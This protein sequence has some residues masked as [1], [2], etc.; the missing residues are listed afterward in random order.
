[1]SP[2]NTKKIVSLDTPISIESKYKKIALAIMPLLG[3]LIWYA[4][5]LFHQT[6]ITQGDLGRHLKNGEIVLHSLAQHDFGTLAKILHTNFY[7][8]VEPAFPFINHHWGSGVIFYL[9]F[10]L[11]SFPLLTVF[12]TALSLVTFYFFLQ[13]GKKHHVWAS[14]LAAF[15]L[16]P[17][18]AE[19]VQI[20]PEVFSY[21]FIGLYLY[22]FTRY[23]DG[24]LK[25]LHLYLLPIA[26]LLWVN[27]H[28]Y[29]FFGFVIL[30]LFFFEE[31]L[32]P[33]RKKYLIHLGGLALLFIAASILNPSGIAGLLY[34]LHIFNNY[35]YQVQEN[36]S[37]L[38]FA[39]VFPW[40]PNVIVYKI[41]AVVLSLILLAGIIKKPSLLKNSLVIFAAGTLLMSL[42]AVRN[43]TLFAYAAAA[44]FPLLIS[45]LRKSKINSNKTV[46]WIAVL[47]LIAIT[48]FIN[49]SRLSVA[50]HELGWQ[51]AP[52]TLAAAQFVREHQLYSPLF[53]D[54]NIGGYATWSAFPD[55]P[56]FV[57]N[58]PE[59]FSKAFF[60]DTYLPPQHDEAAWKK[61]D[62]HYRFNTIWYS[63]SN[64][65]SLPFIVAR[66]TDPEWA[67]IFAD[68]YSIIFV[69]R[70][71]LN[72]SLIQQ[73]EIPKDR[74]SLE[75]I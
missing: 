29:F 30:G 60:T 67:P 41:T 59:A 68:T 42:L 13:L 16:I 75:K 35:A 63:F 25:T 71:D 6:D 22:L 7:S 65:D 11:G 74:F 64:S 72:E 1:M 24:E 23:R 2:A 49:R 19:R 26:Q 8:Y 50:A 33:R 38:N 10:Q 58:R 5:F 61:L 15:F 73:F 51:A 45:N 52:Q 56:P 55:L 37:A 27:L 44:V 69:K 14:Y 34:P 47:L 32:G 54:F 21:F 40:Y 46:Q 17:L 9:L 3:L 12:F 39:R 43:W 57:D 20:R 18:I 48:L 62:K 4:F 70:N 66:L 28:I 31:I 53:N 36:Q